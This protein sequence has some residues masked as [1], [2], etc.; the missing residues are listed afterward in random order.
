MANVFVNHARPWSRLTREDP[1]NRF[2][3]ARRS[4]GRDKLC[5]C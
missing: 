1:V 5:R 3:Y 2:A 4:A